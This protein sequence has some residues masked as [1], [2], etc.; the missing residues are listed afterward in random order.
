[1][2]ITKQQLKQLIKEE[3]SKLREGRTEDPMAPK[4]VNKFSRHSQ[5]RDTARRTKGYTRPRPARDPQG[6]A[7]TMDPRVRGEWGEFTPSE[8]GEYREEDFLR[9]PDPDVSE[10]DVSVD[11][12]NVRVRP[13][14]EAIGG[15]A[16]RSIGEAQTWLR[17]LLEALDGDSIDHVSREP[18]RLSFADYDVLRGIA[19][20]LDNQ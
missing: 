15:G 8:P 7:A 1:M 16:A 20:W 3:S 13:S 11:T 14:S 6:P 18:T 4:G 12:P 19:K 5:L 2:Q 10:F 9:Q 17:E